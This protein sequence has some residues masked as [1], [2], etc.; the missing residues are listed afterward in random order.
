LAGP[1]NKISW[2]GVRPPW[3]TIR[4]L[5]TFHS[6]YM[7]SVTLTQAEEERCSDGMLALPTPPE[8]RE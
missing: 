6:T 1:W 7:L 8:F 2:Y 4:G 3:T 5:A